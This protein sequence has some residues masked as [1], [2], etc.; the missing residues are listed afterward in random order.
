MIDVRV[1]DLAFFD[2]EAIARPVNAE[3]E[4]TTPV[5]RRLERAG[6]EALA[7]QLRVQE[8]LAVGSAV[9]TGAGE[10]AVQ[11]LI[12]G[13]VASATEPVTRRSVA[14]ATTS[15]LQRAV[16]WGMQR[17]AFA[18]FGLGAGNL[19]VDDSA[20]VMVDAIQQHLARARGPASVTVIVETDDEAR[21]F[22]TRLT[23]TTP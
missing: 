5:M 9:V 13:V 1:D 4:A 14:R 23:R 22:S 2:G 16:D 15:A 6:G 19:D 20:D 7:K 11:F 10:L 3:L 12:H 8:P 17:I 18:P 21:A